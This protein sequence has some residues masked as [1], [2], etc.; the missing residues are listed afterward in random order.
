[1][2]DIDGL[3]SQTERQNLPKNAIDQNVLHD[4]VSFSK[5]SPL[6]WYGLKVN[7]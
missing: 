2:K 3:S 5:A 4:I 6:L 7:Q 1:M